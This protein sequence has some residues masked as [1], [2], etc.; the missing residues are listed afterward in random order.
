MLGRRHFFVHTNNLYVLCNTGKAEDI[1]HLFF[2]CLFSNSCWSKLNIHWELQ[3]S[4]EERVQ[5]A[6]LN[7]QEPWFMEIFVFAAWTIWNLRNGVIFERKA[8][9]RRLWCNNFRCLS[10]LQLCKMKEAYRQP[11]CSWLDFVSPSPP[12]SVCSSSLAGFVL[13]LG[14]SCKL[15]K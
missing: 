1:N 10:L 15:S 3:P 9:N 7:F 2:S 11:F 8:C 6:K 4:I 14:K 13:G 5:L 12:P